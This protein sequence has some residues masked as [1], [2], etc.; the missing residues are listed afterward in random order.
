MF[1]NYL[2]GIH[3]KTMALNLPDG[4][5]MI[6]SFDKQSQEYKDFI[7]AINE[8]REAGATYWNSREELHRKLESSEIK[9][10]S[11]EHKEYVDIMNKESKREYEN[12][13]KIKI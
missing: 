2:D 1:N 10:N 13:N 5:V 9:R 7:N 3:L 11:K 4:N 6:L 8:Y 12:I